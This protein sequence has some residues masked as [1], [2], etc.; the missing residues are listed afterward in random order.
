[1]GTV[2]LGTKLTC[3]SCGVRFFDLGKKPAA[4]PKCG[5]VQGPQV[6]RLNPG[7]SRTIGRRPP[8]PF[9][10]AEKQDEPE[11]DAAGDP[12]DGDADEER[13]D[14]DEDLEDEADDVIPPKPDD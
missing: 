11:A 6:S 3:S 7:P 5:A 8:P 1:M 10:P 13:P 4:C 9:V 12:D 14:D 2:S